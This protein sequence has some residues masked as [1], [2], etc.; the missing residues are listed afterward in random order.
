MGKP[1]LLS[2]AGSYDAMLAAVAAGA[3]EVYFGADGFNAR[4]FAKGFSDEELA[5]GIRLCRLHGV[6]T[7][8]TLN[9][10]V[11]DR[12]IPDAV[13]LA[14]RLCEIGADAFIVQ[15]LGLAAKLKCEIP[16]IELHASTQ[17]A[18]HN[19]DGAAELARLGFSRIVL[20]REL[21]FENIRTVTEKGL[22][23]EV[24]Y[25]TETFIHG[26]L[27][28]SH[29]GM[30]LMSSCIGGRS[31]NRG[32]CAQPCRMPGALQPCR[33]PGALQPCRMPGETCGKSGYPLSLKD[34][35]LCTHIKELCKSGTA[36]LKIEGRMK[37]PEYV[38]R[39][40]SIWRKLLDS[41]ENADPDD[42]KA[43]ESIFSRGGFTD[44]YFTK[45]VRRDNRNM[46]GVRS[47]SDKAKTRD[48]SSAFEIPP[49]PKLPLSMDCRVTVGKRAVLR[50]EACGKSVEVYSE[51]EVLPAKNAPM[52]KESLAKNL[53]KTGGTEFECEKL[54]LEIN[55]DAFMPSSA[56]NA[57][58]RCALAALEEAL[59]SHNIPARSEQKERTERKKRR[60]A[61]AAAYR[62]YANEHPRSWSEVL[63]KHAEKYSPLGCIVLPLSAF[64]DGTVDGSGICGAKLGVRLPRV[65]FD[66]EKDGILAAL[67]NAK[68]SGVTVAEVSNISHIPL[69]KNVGFGLIGGVGLNVYNS[70]AAEVYAR[71]GL[72]EITLSPELTLPQMRDLE[73]PDGV[74][75][76]VFAKGRL[77]LMVLESCIV[78]CD[79]KANCAGAALAKGEI[80]LCGLYRDRIG[81][82]FPVYG[83]PRFMCGG[84]SLPCRNIIL[85]SVETD[86]IGKAKLDEVGA[87]TIVVEN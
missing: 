36:S 31:G 40:T 80:P 67:E 81:K 2:P 76:G 57:L 7:N 78:R 55:G 65:I 79:G 18:C 82:E 63:A 20:A 62:I 17:C 60:P 9:T 74:R 34:L 49:V 70:D 3:D 71:L 86:L 44:G 4:A 51:S 12:E 87:E 39:V 26:A 22:T 48:E 10:L 5:D 25:E 19:S 47:D 46:Y 43:L 69:A 11:N 16:E 61:C 59:T 54:T 29:S 37:S 56:I 72:T 14:Y 41:G 6:H 15:D 50:A 8:V 64:A 1:L 33:M 42:I 73:V 75:V 52:T 13:N 27:C 83:E 30:C 45:S 35:S 68:N 84:L 24:K 32:E 77:P 58:R 28:V 53:E 38:Y 66:E 85:N 21:P 23:G